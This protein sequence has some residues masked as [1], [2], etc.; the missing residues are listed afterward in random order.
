MSLVDLTYVIVMVGWLV[1]V[2]LLAHAV[3]AWLMHDE[4]MPDYFRVAMSVFAERIAVLMAIVIVGWPLTIPVL[5]VM[6][7]RRKES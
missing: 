4:D 3:P 7:R 2:G 1:G 5:V 6:S